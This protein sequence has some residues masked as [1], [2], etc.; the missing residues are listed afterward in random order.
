MLLYLAGHSR[1]GTSYSVSCSAC[2]CFATQHSHKVGAKMIGSYLL[3]TRYKVLAK[4]PIDTLDINAYPDSCFTVM[5]GAEDP[6][7]PS[8][9]KSGTRF[10]L[11][12]MSDLCFGKYL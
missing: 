1:T 5:W 6:I 2:F 10:L 12:L 11:M 8:S 4:K 7:D 9:V 3:K